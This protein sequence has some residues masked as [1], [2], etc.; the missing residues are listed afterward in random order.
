MLGHVGPEAFQGLDL[1]VLTLSVA[2]PLA[3]AGVWLG[4]RLGRHRHRD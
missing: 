2:F 1:F 3:I 4:R